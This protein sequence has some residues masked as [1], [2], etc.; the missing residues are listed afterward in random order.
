MCH[1]HEG[2]DAQ[3][4]EVPVEGLPHLR[5]G[6][7]L[8]DR[9]AGLVSLALLA[10]PGDVEKLVKSKVSQGL[11]DWGRPRPAIGAD[12]FLI[13]PDH[14]K[15]TCKTHPDL[16]F[17]DEILDASLAGD[18]EHGDHQLVH[19]VGV[20]GDS[21]GI[22]ADGIDV[23]LV[24]VVIVVVQIVIDIRDNIKYEKSKCHEIK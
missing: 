1:T 23:I 24:G 10:S 20:G 9:P 11:R 21:L 17:P 5:E 7:Q 18:G 2:A 14:D 4:V 13:L 12:C 22:L 3:A 6:G 16:Y 15:V 19:G 8:L